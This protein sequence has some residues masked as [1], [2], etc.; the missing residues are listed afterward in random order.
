MAS[1][2]RRARVAARSDPRRIAAGSQ[3]RFV[4]VG[5]RFA[6]SGARVL[7]RRVHVRR[8]FRSEVLVATRGLQRGVRDRHHEAHQ[9][10]HIPGIYN[11]SM[12][13]TAAMYPKIS[14]KCFVY[15][16]LME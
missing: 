4:G 2:A 7:H 13:N 8:D 6:Q 12:N 5:S 10:K 9:W 3:R 16:Y 11:V 15:V 14:F 1:A